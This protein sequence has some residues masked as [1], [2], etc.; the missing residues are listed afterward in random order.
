MEKSC[1]LEGLLD[2]VISRGKDLKKELDEN[3]MIEASIRSQIEAE[4]QVEPCHPVIKEAFSKVEEI[5]PTNSREACSTPTD[6]KK[7]DEISQ[8]FLRTP[9]VSP[10]LIIN[11]RQRHVDE[12]GVSAFVQ[13]ASFSISPNSID[14]A[15]LNNPG[16]PSY[17]MTSDT[18]DDAVYG[19]GA[20]FLGGSTLH[21][22]TESDR[23][24]ETSGLLTGLTYRAGGSS[25]N[26]N[27]ARSES[28]DG[29]HTRQLSPTLTS[30]FDTIDF[31]TGMSGHRGLNNAKK[32]HPP[33]GGSPNFRAR[34]M[35]SE[36]RGIG[37]VRGP[38]NKS[39]TSNTP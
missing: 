13:P 32:L 28:S 24:P 30:S 22:F 37:R 14:N 27:R 20:T 38:L 5:S 26:E 7:M 33:A 9:D 35:M 23:P 19:C 12:N 10:D 4:L 39:S 16:L 3:D 25:N 6:A 17:R 18:F 34:L 31:R 8:P 15:D 36:H 2:T 1:R 21:L 29:H 11:E